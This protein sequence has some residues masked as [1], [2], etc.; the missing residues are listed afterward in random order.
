VVSTVAALAAARA[1]LRVEAGRQCGLAARVLD[2]SLL[3][4]AFR[5][6]DL[7]LVHK[8]SSQALADALAAV[9]PA[10]VGA[11]GVGRDRTHIQEGHH[12]FHS[13]R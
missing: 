12:G 8:A 3:I 11:T 9:D 1:V 10:D 6:A 7:L 4:E 5:Q 2:Q 13:S